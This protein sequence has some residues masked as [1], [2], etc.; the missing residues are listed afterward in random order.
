MD[1]RHVMMN[2]K[3]RMK[4]C[5]FLIFSCFFLLSCGGNSS[6]KTSEKKSAGQSFYEANCT[7]CHG[8]DG[9]LCALGAKDLSL[10]DMSKEQMMEIITN[11]KST[12]TSF[13]SVMTPEEISRLADY[14]ST[15]KK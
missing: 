1:A 8:E 9:K 6:D 14:V 3:L 15:L 11:G 10:S 2:E 12:M 5:C 13:S 4:N 7:A